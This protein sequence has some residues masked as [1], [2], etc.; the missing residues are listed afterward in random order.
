MTL[1][2]FY[3]SEEGSDAAD[4]DQVVSCNGKRTQQEDDA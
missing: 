1:H 3:C 2:G 4:G